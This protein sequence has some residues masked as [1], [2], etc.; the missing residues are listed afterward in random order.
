M[1]A[2][3]FAAV[4]TSV[5]APAVLVDLDPVGGGID[6][7]LGIDD[8]PGARWSGLRVDGG[9]LDPDALAAGLPQWQGGWVLA[10]DEAPDPASVGQVAR[11]AAGLGPVVLDL[12]RAPSPLRE[13]GLAEC[14]LCV[15][16][17]SASDVRTL[18]AAGAVLRSLPDV[19]VGVVLRR[20]GFEVGEA[21]DLLG[22]P[23]LGVLPAVDRPATRPARRVA[24]GIVDG[25]RLGDV[26]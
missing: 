7:L 3:T 20:G 4:V 21:V 8:L 12:P 15:L 14:E 18:V 13:A 22:V 16:V 19:P 26:A 6:V 23:L 9:H 10:A 17:A 24:A 1:G 5:A 11:A 2:S 25:V